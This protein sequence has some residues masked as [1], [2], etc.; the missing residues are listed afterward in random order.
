MSLSQPHGG[1]LINRYQPDLDLSAITKQV[2]VDKIALS[3]LELIANGAY[4]PLEGFMGAE[5]YEQVVQ[6]MRLAS[7]EVWSIPITLPVS[8]EAASTIKEGDMVKLSYEGTAYGVIEVREKYRPDKTVEAQQ[9]YR[10]TD[11]AHPGVKKLFERP[12]V[13]LGGPVTLVKRLPKQ[14]FAEFYLDPSET[15]A[16]FRERGWRTVVGFQTRNPVHRA[17]EYIQKCALEIV[18]GLF[19]NPLVGETKADDIPADVR[20]ESYQVLL[21]HYYP[22]ER[23]FLA[24]FPAAMRY[25]GPREAIFHA[26][27]RKNYGCTHFIVGR[28]HA[29]VGNYYGTYDAQR[30]FDHFSPAELGITPLFFEHS[31]YCYRCGG[32]ASTKTCPHGEEDRLILSGTKVRQ[33]LSRG[34]VPPPEFSRKEVVEVLIQGLKQPTYSS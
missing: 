8:E 9:V 32:M 17:H 14:R 3:D 22:P 5:D 30:I 15:R 25:A 24:V 4:S 6:H 19:L 13:Y 11:L 12:S 33:M 23:V 1:T 28:D 7:G 34:E 16:K 10:T 18:D 31:F 26:L 27:V 29:G 20:M 2:E 21:K